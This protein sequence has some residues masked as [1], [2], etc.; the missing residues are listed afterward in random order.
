MR[1]YVQSRAGF[2]LG[3]FARKIERV[4]VRFDHARR[5]GDSSPAVRCRIKV[6]VSRLQNVVAEA[7]APSARQAFGDAI[8]ASARWVKHLQ[9]RR[10]RLRRKPRARVAP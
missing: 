8:T 10:T 6:V 9:E 4:S 3:R 5:I 1:E 2:R 7:T